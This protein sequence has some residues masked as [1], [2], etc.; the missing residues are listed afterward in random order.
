MDTG[1]LFAVALNLPHSWRISQ[2][3]FKPTE[4][5]S[6]ELHIHIA[7]QRGGKVP[8]PQKTARACA[9]RIELQEIYEQS[10]HRDE[11][12]QRLKKLCSWM[13]YAR[14]EP[15]KK[16][17]GTIRNHWDEILHYFEHPYTNAILEGVNSIIQNIKRRAR[18]FRNDEYFKTM[19]YLGC[20]KLNL[21][22]QIP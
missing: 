7:F 21:N 14:L 15:M 5:G 19:I 6:M 1:S 10:V 3:E 11:A 9:M 13:M 8:C 17:C 12:E 20:G 2:V 16:F 22:I 18:G 4:D